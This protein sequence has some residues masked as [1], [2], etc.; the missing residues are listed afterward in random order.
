MFIKQLRL[1]TCMLV[2]THY[3]IHKKNIKKINKTPGY[4]VGL[5]GLQ[6]MSCWL[7]SAGLYAGC[8]HSTEVS[9]ITLISKWRFT[10]RC[11]QGL[12][13]TDWAV[14]PATSK[15]RIFYL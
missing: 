4:L 1:A 10:C 13:D 8:S 7:V 9:T 2:E 12:P 5:T 6:V 15:N 11:I 14:Y 3:K